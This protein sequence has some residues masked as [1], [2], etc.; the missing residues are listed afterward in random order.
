MRKLL[1]VAL[2]ATLII[3]ATPAL[4]QLSGTWAGTGKG[5]AYPPSGEII[6]PWQNWQGE[7]PNSEDSFSGEWWDADGNHGKFYGKLAPYCTP[8]TIVFKGYWTWETMAGIVKAG[9]FVMDFYFLEDY[10]EGTWTSIWP[11]PGIPGTMKGKKV[12]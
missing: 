6:Y 4:A 11:S 3:G 8:E 10:C 9:E 5:A 1:L 2:A 12:N 7:I